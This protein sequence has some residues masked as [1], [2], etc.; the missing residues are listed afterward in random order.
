MN[1]KILIQNAKI[2][3]EG[4]VFRSDLLIENGYIKKIDPNIIVD[5]SVQIIEADG[6]FLLPGLIDDQVHFREPGLTHKATIA[7][8]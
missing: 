3:N 1:Q 6:Q 7:S 4:L 8:E 5:S 2:V